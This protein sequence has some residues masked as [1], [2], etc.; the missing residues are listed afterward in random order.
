MSH[1]TIKGRLLSFDNFKASFAVAV[2]LPAP[3]KPH[4]IITVGDLPEKLSVAGSVPPIISVNSSFTIFTSCCEGVSDSST[5]APNA[6]SD[7][8]LTNSLTILKFTSASRSA[9]LISRIASL[10]S[11]SVSFPLPLS[12]LNT[13]CSLSPK[14]SKAILCTPFKIHMQSEMSLSI[15]INLAFVPLSSISETTF[16]ISRSPPLIFS[17]LDTSPSFSSK[18][19]RCFSPCFK[20]AIHPDGLFPYRLLSH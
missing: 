20:N 6:F 12:F 16:A 1:A 13:P 3:C 18:L 4:I 10:M 11:F 5:S 15:S 14:L 19:L 8:L 9:S 2:V 17:N 7:T